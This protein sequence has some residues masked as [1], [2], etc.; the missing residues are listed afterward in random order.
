MLVVLLFIAYVAL[1]VLLS[2]WRAGH[3]AARRKRPRSVHG[4]RRT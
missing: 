3:D 1:V 2:L 4:R